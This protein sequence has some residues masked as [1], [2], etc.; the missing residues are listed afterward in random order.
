[1]KCSKCGAELSADMRFCA[2]CGRKIEEPMTPPPVMEK[3]EN[4]HIF[5]E[6]PVMQNSKK[7]DAPKPL[8]DKIKD[9][10]SDEWSKLD[11]YGKI[12]TVALIVFV[13][14][15]FVAFLFG[16]TTA[17]I[18]AILQIVLI[19]VGILMKKQVIK[20]P[21]SW[22]HNY[23]PYAHCHSYSTLCEPFQS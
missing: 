21:K 14:L 12:A 22:L 10:V 13:M 15:C 8:A 20:T 23:S 6:Q 19:I 4:S 11:T 1:M 18:I 3:A 5:N 16:K 9:K 7:S 17:G 2:Y